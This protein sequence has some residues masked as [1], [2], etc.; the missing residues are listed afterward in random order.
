MPLMMDGDDGPEDVAPAEKK[1]KEV[2]TTTN[3]VQVQASAPSA[4]STSSL[5]QPSI[6]DLPPELR[7]IT[8]GLY[9]VGKLLGRETEKCWKDM[10]DLTEDLAR[11]TPGA[12]T[13]NG[14][15]GHMNNGASS[16]TSVDQSKKLK[17]LEFAQS[18]RDMFTKLLVIWKWTPKNDALRRLIDLWAWILESDE[19]PN[20]A[21]WW[22]G[23]QRYNSDRWKEPNPDIRTALEVLSTGKASWLPDFGFI[24]PEPMTPEDILKLLRRTNTDLSIR[25]NLHEDLPRTLRTYSIKNGRVTFNIPGEFELDVSVQDDN[26][27]SPFYFIDLRFTFTPQIEIPDGRFLAGLEPEMNSLLA[28]SGLVGCYEYLHNFC[29]TLKIQTLKRQAVQLAMDTYANALRVE[30]VRRMLIVQ[31]WIESP[32]SKNWF[33]IGVSSSQPS[34]KRWFK[35]DPEPPALT[36]RWMRNSKEVQTV[37]DLHIDWSSLSMERILQ[38]I[39]SSHICHIFERI[40]SHLE[41]E[42]PVGSTLASKLCLDDADASNSYLRVT[43]AKQSNAVELVIEPI[44]GRFAFKPPSIESTR[45]EAELNN[46]PNPCEHA[47]EKIKRLLALSLRSHDEKQAVQFGWEIALHLRIR[48]EDLHKAFNAKKILQSTF[49][50]VPS[51][52]S[53]WMVALVIDLAG[54][55]WWAVEIDEWITGGSIRK[56]MKMLSRRPGSTSAP[57]DQSFLRQLE[58]EIVAAIG[59]AVCER[60]LRDRDVPHEWSNQEAVTNNGRYMADMLCIRASRLLAKIVPTVQLPADLRHAVLRLSHVGFV[61]RQGKLY[62]VFQACLRTNAGA[63]LGRIRA[64]PDRRVH[65]DQNGGFKTW[66]RCPFAE[67]C[68]D[69]LLERLASIYRLRVLVDALRDRGICR[70]S[71]IS[72]SSVAFTYNKVR[73]LKATIRLPDHKSG[74]IALELDP[75]NPQYRLRPLLTESLNNPAI[76]PTRSLPLFTQNLLS[77]SPLTRAF[78]LIESIVSE[79]P[80]TMFPPP[81]FESRSETWHRIVY[82]PPN[83]TCSFDVCLRVHDNRT[84]WHIADNIT[85]KSDDRP[86]YER[87]TPPLGTNPARQFIR[88]EC[89]ATALRLLWRARADGWEGINSGII[90]PVSSIEA[91]LIRLDEVVRGCRQEIGSTTTTESNTVQQASRSRPTSSSQQPQLHQQQHLRPPQLANQQVPR[92]GQNMNRSNMQQRPNIQNRLGF[93]PNQ[94]MQQGR[95]PQAQMQGSRHN[96]KPPPEVITLD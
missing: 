82:S 2:M 4:P 40:L 52:T 73:S 24:P 88:D 54:E 51:W 83:P 89:L 29:L 25:I 84:V 76:P 5:K 49:F 39:I 53:K 68:V 94:G 21:A 43:L 67:S 64:A 26:H 12:S 35:R 62:H 69:A 28:S 60:H 3:G 86:P 33:E 31:Y 75:K 23:Q 10:Q 17:I 11:M 59:T 65:F 95:A 37:Q 8:E 93:A 32:G 61:T 46:D 36:I 85:K 19:H 58:S 18:H 92:P 27:E 91:A 90:A 72:L 34:K 78:G 87:D 7:H 22:I 80:F 20:Q 77:T 13:T 14:V 16:S 70:P 42:I 71:E 55:S 15:H 44:T 63:H 9:S 6:L 57:V 79:P 66:V 81:T 56:V 38:R 30:M 48:S 50:R 41:S 47:A 45:I 1:G 96:Q 74:K